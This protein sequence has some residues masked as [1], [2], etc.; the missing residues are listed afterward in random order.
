MILPVEEGSFD[1][2]R[3]HFFCRV[4]GLYNGEF[5]GG[6][7]QRRKNNRFVGRGGGR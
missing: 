2:R 4:T 6:A 3:M 1:R 5:T 7:E